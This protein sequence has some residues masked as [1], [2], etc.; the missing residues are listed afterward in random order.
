MKLLQLQIDKFAIL[1][2]TRCLWRRGLYILINYVLLFLKN[3]F[4]NKK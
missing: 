4:K 3:M 2:L 1:I